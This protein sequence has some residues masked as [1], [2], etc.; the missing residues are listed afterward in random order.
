VKE[1]DEMRAKY[2]AASTEYL[3]QRM[4][5]IVIQEAKRQLGIVLQKHGGSHL[6]I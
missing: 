2:Q 6:P 1:S 5:D 3:F 4:G